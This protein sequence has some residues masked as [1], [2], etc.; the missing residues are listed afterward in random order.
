[1]SKK[2]RAIILFM[3]LLIPSCVFAAGDNTLVIDNKTPKGDALKGFVY[4]LTYPDG[5]KETIDMTQEASKMLTLGDGKYVLKEMKRPEGIGP[6]EPQTITLP[7]NGSKHVRYQPKHIASVDKPK[8][9]PRQYTNTGSAFFIM[10]VVGMLSS[11]SL[12]FYCLRKYRQLE[13]ARVKR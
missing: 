12:G 11:L 6:L 3:L 13:L 1:M 4:E 5:K 2:F 8:P 7:S 9:V 10:P